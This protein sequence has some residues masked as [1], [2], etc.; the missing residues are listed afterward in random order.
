MSPSC[1]A[2][3]KVSHRVGTHQGPGRDFS[4]CSSEGNGDQMYTMMLDLPLFCPQSTHFH[5]PG[6][7][8]QLSDSPTPP[9]LEYY[10]GLHTNSEILNKNK[11]NFT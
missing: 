7:F 4:G 10:S 1:F 2:C 6:G 9:P 5:L 11:V 8:L 3:D